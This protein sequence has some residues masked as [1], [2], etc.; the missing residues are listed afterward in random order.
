MACS[1]NEPTTPDGQPGGTSSNA[2][3]GAS[4]AG[5]HAGGGGTSGGAGQSSAG[6]AA[7]GAATT[8]SFERDVAP[9]FADSC[10]Y[11]HYTGSILVDI[12]QPFTPGSGLVDSLNSWASDHPEGNTPARNVAPGDPDHSFVLTKIGNPSLDVATAG[13]FMP[14][15]VP[16]VTDEEVT[17]LRSWISAGAQND[18]TF[19]E[20]IRP[21][22]GTAGRLGRAGG[23]CTYCHWAG[24]QLPNL[25]DPFDPATGA[26]GIVS[27]K[28]QGRMIIEPGNPDM[29]F[30]IAKVTSDVLPGPQGLPMPAHFDPLTPAQ[31]ETVR[32]WIRE[33]AQDN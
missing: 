23:K 32:T 16:R 2:G 5:G 13:E 11:C 33:G 6:G 21:I 22:F 9:I 7:A 8:V 29:S 27:R 28:G 25:S 10:V 12:A 15:A 4:S 17:A 3:T 30:L 19:S 24:G 31:V 18:S 26:V 14:W 1:S 20:Q